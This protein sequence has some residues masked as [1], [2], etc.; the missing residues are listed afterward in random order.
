MKQHIHEN[1]VIYPLILRTR[2]KWK[3]FDEKSKR[4]EF[5][6]TKV[7]LQIWNFIKH[8]VHFTAASVVI[9]FVC[10]YFI[11]LAEFNFQFKV[12]LVIE[13]LIG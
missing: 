3:L 5:H 2:M 9:P 13:W 8:N 12:H 10:S 1:N 6:C 11:D 4:E 7:K